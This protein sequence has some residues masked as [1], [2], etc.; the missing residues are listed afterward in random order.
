VILF[1]TAICRNGPAARREIGCA[2]VR[3]T[4]CFTGRS[5]VLPPTA[6]LTAPRPRRQATKMFTVLITFLVVQ[7]LS[8]LV[9]SK[10]NQ[11]WALSRGGIEAGHGHYPVVVALH[12]LFFLS[13]VAERHFLPKGWD[14]LWPFWL[15]ILIL[16]QLLRAWCILSLGRF[17]TTKIIVIP[18]E[19]PVLKGPYRFIRHPTYVAVLVEILAI[20]ILCGAYVTAAVFSILNSL[21]LWWRIREEERA[22]ALLE[23]NDLRRLPRFIPGVGAK[24]RLRAGGNGGCE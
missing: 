24:S 4:V 7:R 8:E 22:L 12:V 19:R 20:P 17:W 9:V 5:L 21:V 15:G 11:R 14:P 6:E 16:S 3:N 13:L 23:G 10:R 2:S 1:A 18:G